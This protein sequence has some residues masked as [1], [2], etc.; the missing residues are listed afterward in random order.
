V[1]VPRILF[2]VPGLLAGLLIPAVTT[3]HHAPANAVGMVSMDFAKDVVVLHRGERLTLFN[4]SDLVHVIGPGNNGHIASPQKGDPI[5]GFHLMPTNSTYTTGPWN[6]L[7]TFHLTCSVHPDMNL[8]V[9]VV[10]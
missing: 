10:R 8:E 9:V 1:S 4:S 6:T 2:V 3:P 5:L 7:G